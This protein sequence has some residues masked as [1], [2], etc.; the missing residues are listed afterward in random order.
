M[1]SDDFFLALDGPSALSTFRARGLLARIQAIEPAAAQLH[2]QHV[3]FVHTRGELDAQQQARLAALLDYGEP[4][5]PLEGR[6]ARQWLVVP[7]L[8]TISP[9]ASK[10]TDIA[11]NCGVDGVLRIERGTRYGLT[12][13]GGLFGSRGLDADKAQRIAALLHDRMT[14]SVVP[15]DVECAQLFRE[16]PGKA[17]ARI[18]VSTGGREALARANAEM[19]LA[20]SDDEIDYLLDAYSA[21]RR[22]P[23]DVE[24]MMFA[25]AN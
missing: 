19:G 2:A 21:M 15:T 12:L 7:R 16:L 17:M 24:L 9:W 1:S 25:Q 10:A 4:A 13:K 6:D 14:E 3:H 5:P 11:H 8:G 22:D 23:T 18:A 20:L